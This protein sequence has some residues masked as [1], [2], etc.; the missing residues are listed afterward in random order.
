MVGV[1][2]VPQPTKLPLTILIL[3]PHEDPS[4]VHPATAWPKLFLI[5]R[6]RRRLERIIVLSMGKRYR[7]ESRFSRFLNRLFPKPE[8]DGN[9]EY[10]YSPIVFVPFFELFQAVPATFYALTMLIA[11]RIKIDAIYCI[12][13]G[14]PYFVPVALF[15]ASLFRKPV[16]FEHGD[17]FWEE[18]GGIKQKV[19]KLYQRLAMKSSHV[20]FITAVSPYVFSYL[21]KK[22]PMRRIVFLPEGYPDFFSQPASEEDVE[23]LRRKYRLHGKKVVLYAGTVFAP[24]IPIERLIEA[25]AM[26]VTRR[27][28]VTFVILGRNAERL[29]PLLSSS[30]LSEYFLLDF[31]PHEE[32]KTW[33]SLADVCIHIRKAPVS[34]TKVYEYMVCGKP[35]ILATEDPSKY[36]SFLISGQNCIITS[37]D[38]H[39]ISDAILE[40]LD[41]RELAYKI[42]RSAYES[43]K[44]FSWDYFAETLINMIKEAVGKYGAAIRK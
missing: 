36:D 31:R 24:S 34:P 33:I 23:D 18:I 41:N 32:I 43:I 39:G 38:P 15:V 44:K 42:G 11:R 13:I 3:V 19:Y 14:E 12:S 22:Y 28:D 26:I 30:G 20:K 10:H 1:R 16:I 8:Y 29:K 7:G 9:V 6:L 37:L 35:V 4:R 21:K 25:A 27:K 5:P 2:K 40:V 17:P